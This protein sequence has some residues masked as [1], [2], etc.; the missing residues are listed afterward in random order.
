MAKER[1]YWNEEIETM[2]LEKLKQLQERRLREVV[3]QAY[4]KTAFYRRSFD[5]AGVKPEDIKTLDDLKKLPLVHSA[6]DFRIAP[7]VDR[8]AVPFEEVRY[9]ESTSGTTGIPMALLWSKR[10]WDAI[11]EL[12]PRIRWNLGVRPNDVAQILTGFPC[13]QRGYQELGATVIS[14][15]AGRGILDN[16]IHVGQMVGITV[17][18][19]LPSLAIKYLE[20]AR[21]LGYNIKE[22]P[23]HLIVGGGEPLAKS[24]EEEIGEE[25]GV[26][27]RH[28]YGSVDACVVATECEESRMHTYMDLLIV[29]IVDPETGEVLD[30]GQQGEVVVTLLWPEATPIIRY[31][32]GDVGASLLPYEPCPC[33]ITHATMSMPK[34][35]L[36]HSVKIT[37]KRIFPIDVEDVV[38]ST[39]D[40]GADYQVIVDKPGDLDRLKVKAEYKPEVKD[41]AAL[42]KQ[43]EERLSRDLGVR[44]EVELVP[45]GTLGRPLFKAQ[46][47]ITNFG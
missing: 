10:D 8:L 40:L 4:E 6:E 21:G 36:V 34:G 16:Q 47:I 32:T 42:K 33:G 2:P 44:S 38:A 1:R 45:L 37:G 18:E 22:G 46:R 35:R 27:F 23:L 11:M 25:Y 28:M 26:K 39:P 12:E 31:R 24:Y 20:R 5:K 29:E 9:V 43:L 30:L 15:N 17:I 3:T 41:M 13:C 7:I 14:L 19:H